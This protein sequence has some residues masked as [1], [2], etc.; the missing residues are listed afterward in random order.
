MIVKTLHTCFVF[1]S[2]NANMDG[3]VRS[4]G[5]KKATVQNTLQFSLWYTVGLIS[6]V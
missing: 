2:L 6:D 1:E 3:T 4:N 5:V